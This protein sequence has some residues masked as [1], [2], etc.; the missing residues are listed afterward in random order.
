M[1]VKE[2]QFVH[3]GNI[4]VP[5]VAVTLRRDEPRGVELEL[6]SGVVPGTAGGVPGSSRRSV[7]A[8]FHR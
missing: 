7:T 1:P 8:T 3:H 4:A 6:L 5:K 2:V